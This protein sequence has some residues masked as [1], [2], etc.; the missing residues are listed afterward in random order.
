MKHPK[1]NQKD[2]LT[3]EGGANIQLG[4]KKPLA[5]KGERIF[6][7]PEDIE[8]KG[9]DQQA[10]NEQKHRQQLA[11]E[12]QKEARRFEKGIDSDEDGN[13]QMEFDKD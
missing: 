13:L 4:T 10:I 1:R 12:R 5:F 8:F 3:P 9:V 7:D 11:R 2:D 6:L